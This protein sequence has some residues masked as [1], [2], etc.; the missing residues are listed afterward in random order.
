MRGELLCAIGLPITITAA[1]LGGLNHALMVS[2]GVL[3]LSF[4]LFLAYKIGVVGGLFRSAAISNW[5]PG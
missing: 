4:G 5:T 1:R 2:A 3:S